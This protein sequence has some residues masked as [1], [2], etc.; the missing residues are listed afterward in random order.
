MKPETSG[1]SSIGLGII[2][3]GAAAA[4]VCFGMGAGSYI[5]CKSRM[6]QEEERLTEA[7][8]G[9]VIEP[10]RPAAVAPVVLQRPATP[11]S[12]GIQYPDLN[13]E[14]IEIHDSVALAAITRLSTHKP[15]DA[16]RRP[17]IEGTAVQGW[18]RVV[19]PVGEPVPHVE[20][21]QQGAAQ[22]LGEV[23]GKQEVQDTGVNDGRVAHA[24]TLRL[25]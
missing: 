21:A 23:A 10:L 14:A 11:D 2:A 22:V 8:D 24:E 18:G 12:S 20:P 16:L 13:L 9:K 15:H 5:L 4:L 19:V 1:E 7:V 25:V 17:G 3:G 6:R